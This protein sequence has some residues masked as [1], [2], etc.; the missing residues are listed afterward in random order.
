M[1]RIPRTRTKT[2]TRSGGYIETANDGTLIADVHVSEDYVSTVSDNVGSPVRDS[3]F[4]SFQVR[5][6]I[7]IS[8]S[9][10]TPNGRKRE[11]SSYPLKPNPGSS[12]ADLSPA[13]LPA[14]W[15]L[16]TVAR[17]NPSRPM[18]TPLT[19][20]QDMIQ[21]PGMLRDVGRLMRRPKKSAS[22]KDLANHHL[23][24][25]FGWMPFIDDMHKLLDFQT[26]VQRRLN[27][28]RKMQEDPGGLRR[29]IRFDKSTS[30][31]VYTGSILVGLS[32][33][34]Y[35][36]NVD[37]T[38][39]SWATI[40]WKANTTSLPSVPQDM[41][42]NKLARRVLLGLTPEGLAK[43]AWDV[44]PWTWMINWFSD[45]GNLALARSNT[46]QGDYTHLCGMEHTKVTCSPGSVSYVNM[47][48]ANV[49]FTGSHV[50]EQKLRFVAGG[51]PQSSLKLPIL[52]NF[53]LSILGSLAVQRLSR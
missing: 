15:E 27:E 47:G 26:H 14:G 4:G 28:I 35:K 52:D 3:A 5:P 46:V 10:S 18:V 21:L 33:I 45:V 43:G 23:A 32:A 30:T 16:A 22:P 39:E 12:N 37:V 1:P 7:L 38:K 8:G 9:A 13:R 42:N 41:S 24:V 48:K 17:S 50:E 19:M 36:V 11:F 25:A 53:R 49:Q 34:R 2:V 40:R 29:K 20:I 31:G 6:G 44:L 51:P